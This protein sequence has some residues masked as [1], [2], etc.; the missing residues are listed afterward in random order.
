[1]ARNTKDPKSTASAVL[2]AVMG[3]TDRVFTQADFGELPRTAVSLALSRLAKQGVL[4]KVARGVYYRP[5]QTVLG[6]S[7]ARQGSVELLL[8]EGA[9]PT[10]LSAASLLGFSTQQPS[11]HS[12][13]ISQRDPIT[14]LN[15]VRMV[16]MRPEH[17]LSVEEGALLEFIRDRAAWSE[18]SDRET[19]SKLKRLLKGQTRFD[20]LALAARTEPPRVRAIL[21]ALGELSG[22]RKRSLQQLRS[23]LNPT[24]RYDFGRLR[25]LPN[26]KSWWAK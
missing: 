4:S 26:A 18:L 8:L 23:S 2:R 19:L 13:A 25:G 24:S 17:D 3:N 15:G 20:R 21:G 12:Y 11:R 7:K 6:E 14:R 16:R 1:M 5:R 9:R 10:A 22:A